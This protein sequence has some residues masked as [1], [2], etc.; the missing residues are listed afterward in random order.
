MDAFLGETD[1]AGRMP[2][3]GKVAVIAVVGNED[4]A[5]HASGRALPGADRHG[6]TFPP[7]GTAYW[8][9]EAMGKIDFKDLPKVPDKVTET[10]KMRRAAPRIS[11]ACSRTSPIRAC[12]AEPGQIQGAASPA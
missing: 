2:S 10:V 12:R 4:G 8:V 7:S 3:F 1:D 9:G 6:W 11:R 5:H